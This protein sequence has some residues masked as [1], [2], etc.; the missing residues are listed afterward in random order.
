MVLFMVLTTGPQRGVRQCMVLFVVL[1]TGPQRRVR[2]CMV[3]FLVMTTGTTAE[4]ETVYGPLRG[5]DNR[6]H[7]GGCD[8]AW[9]SSW[10]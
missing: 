4:G 6:D 8:S 9:S 5:T 3:L 10:Y 2:Q 1:T 7:N